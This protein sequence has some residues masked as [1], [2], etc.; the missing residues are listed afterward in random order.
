M[1]LPAA[2][3]AAPSSTCGRGDG[4]RAG[5]QGSCCGGGLSA[6]TGATA[7]STKSRVPLHLGPEAARPVCPQAKDRGKEHGSQVVAAWAESRGEGGVSM[8]RGHGITPS[9]PQATGSSPA[10]HEAVQVLRP[11]HQVEERLDAHEAHREVCRWGGG[12]GGVSMRRVPALL[13]CTA[14]CCARLCCPMRC[15]LCPSRL[16]PHQPNTKPYRC[17]GPLIM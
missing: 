4:G 17:S 7:V 2:L 16:A 15:I 6:S 8:R 3:M 9:V 14:L 10:K 11:T 5:Q 12:V 13:Q 1:K